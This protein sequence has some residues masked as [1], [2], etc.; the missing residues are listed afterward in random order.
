[1]V[2]LLFC[3]QTNKRPILKKS[4]ETL[5]ENMHFRKPGN[6]LFFST[7]KVKWL[8][9]FMGLKY[10]C[11]YQFVKNRGK[12]WGWFQAMLILPTCL[13]CMRH[14]YPIGIYIGDIMVFPPRTLHLSQQCL[15]GFLF[16]IKRKEWV[17]SVQFQSS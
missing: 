17:V 14:K 13:K 10:Y 12:S 7:E 11:G 8:A 16:G 1:M 2:L 15:H 6:S 4:F 5:G 9:Y 3:K